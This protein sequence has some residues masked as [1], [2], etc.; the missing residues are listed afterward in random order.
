MTLKDKLKGKKLILASQSPRRK[1]LLEGCDLKFEVANNY[2]VKEIYDPTLSPCEI[3]ESL[4]LLKSNEFPRQLSSNEIVITADTIVVL[5]D[6]I[7]G[8][9]K[10]RKEAIVMLERMSGKHHTVITGVAIRDI[11]KAKSFSVETDVWFRNL[12][13]EEIEYYVD[14]YSPYDKAGAYG[15]QEW[16]GHIGI[17]RI[18]G[19][20]YNVMGLPIQTLYIYLEQFIDNAEL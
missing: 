19:S 11:H 16:I 7:L 18:E 3:V 17:S 20:F 6:K 10:D 13:T 15:I 12:K 5:D 14:N 9:P 8:K 4:A 1:S 2:N